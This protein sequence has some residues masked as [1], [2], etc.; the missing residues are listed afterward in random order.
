VR[1]GGTISMIGVLAGSQLDISLGL[2]VTRHIR[3]QGIT[4]GS[5]D[6]FRTM[7]RAISQQGMR[8]VV[9]RVYGFEQLHQALQ[10]LA[11]G[12]HFGKICIAH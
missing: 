8:P 10:H 6:D 3:L 12:K 5:G 9:D 7:V 4:V 2:I 11:S 1:P